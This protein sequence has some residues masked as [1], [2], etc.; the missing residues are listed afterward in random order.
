MRLDNDCAVKVKE[1]QDKD[2][3]APGHVLL[4]PGGFNMLLQ[5]SG[6]KYYVAVLN[7]PPA[8]R[9][10]P[11][12]EVEWV[13]KESRRKINEVPNS[14]F[15]MKANLIIIATGFSHVVHDGLVKKFGLKL[16]NAGNI[17][18]NNYQTGESSIFSAGDSVTGALLVAHA[19]NGGRNAAAM[20]D[21]LE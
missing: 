16:D 3:V 18:V 2:I 13:K 20:N 1:A 15:T 7:G 10:K 14:G 21:W 17:S 12:I 4:A 5:R 11:S 8:C 19:I 6:S 9:Q